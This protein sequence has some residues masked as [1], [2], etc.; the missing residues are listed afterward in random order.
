VSRI[1]PENTN[2]AEQVEVS[3]KAESYIGHL[4]YLLEKSETLGEKAYF[5]LSDT[6]I[7]FNR[8]YSL[9]GTALRSIAYH[10]SDAL[11]TKIKNYFHDQ[12]TSLAD[13]GST[14]IH[15]GEE[16]DEEDQ[17]QDRE[18]LVVFKKRRIVAALG[19]LVV[20]NALPHNMSEHVPDVLVHFVVFYL[21]FFR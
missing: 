10:P 8:T 1:D 20:A 16:E 13:T 2:R 19:K 3:Q 15:Q 6:L 14:Q 7:L 21:S 17:G 12:L 18:N 9:Y 5:M 11:V 4:E